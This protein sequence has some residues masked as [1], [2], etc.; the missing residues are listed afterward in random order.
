MNLQG[1]I[2]SRHVM[3]LASPV[4]SVERRVYSWDIFF[5]NVG[6]CNLCPLC[7]SASAEDFIYTS[8][9]ENIFI[10]GVNDAED[11]VKT[12]EAF[13]LLGEESSFQTTSILD[14]WGRVQT[15]WWMKIFRLQCLTSLC[16]RKKPKTTSI[17]L[18]SRTWK[19]GLS[20]LLNC[21]FCVCLC[22][23]RCGCK[24]ICQV[25]IKP[26]VNIVICKVWGLQQVY[27][28]LYFIEETFLK[29]IVVLK[30]IELYCF[31]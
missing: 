31:V 27:T 24:L 9:G 1:N 3:A 12:R 23:L 18:A 2:N 29:K 19:G 5:A 17:N 16:L 13:T 30:Y 6:W 25:T 20:L 21:F 22:S 10:E 4:N 14:E 7:L 15:S 11:F 26:P 28:S 8:L